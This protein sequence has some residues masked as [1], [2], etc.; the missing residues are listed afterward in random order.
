M[1]VKKRLSL[2]NRR[3][4]FIVKLNK[5]IYDPY[6]YNV[7]FRIRL[8]DKHQFFSNTINKYYFIKAMQ[9][10]KNFSDRCIRWDW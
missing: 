4:G 6:D 10:V 8:V 9:V 5:L 2:G 3:N 1:H 7:F